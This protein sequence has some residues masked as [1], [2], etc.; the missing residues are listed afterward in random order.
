MAAVRLDRLSKTF[1]WRKDYVRAVDEVDLE[2]AD[3]EFMV[4]VGPSGCGKS[5]T[6]RL[7][8][9][10]EAPTAGRVFIDDKE[11]THLQPKDRDVA[12]VFQN[13]ALYPHMTAFDNLAF[14]LKM[15]RIPK[16]EIARRVAETARW[17]GL[18]RLLDRR[19]ATLSGGEQQRVALGRA[20]VRR[21]RVFLFDEPLANFDAALRLAAR[22]ELKR[23]HREFNITTIHVTHDQEEAMALADRLVVMRDGRVQQVGTPQE[24]YDR[25]VNRFVGGFL[26][27]PPMRFIE[28][29]LRMNGAAPVV[30]TSVG[31][32]AITAS[33][34][35]RCRVH[36]DQPV[37]L[38][39]R[40]EDAEFISGDHD[41]SNP[42]GGNSACE[43]MLS[44][45][46]EFVES[47][48]HCLHLG[49]RTE[50]EWKFVI[51]TSSG[52]AITVGTQGHLWL[53][54]Q[55]THLFAGHAG[56]ERLN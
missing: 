38:G 39:F 5:T 3:G 55:R 47:L 37:S 43:F 33:D 50:R 31:P 56:G 49:L 1:P 16:V 53:N 20:M 27:T 51:R 44:A 11:V 34:S 21:P 46:V 24:I 25:P 26:G 2:V 6:L 54:L 30:E 29:T 22:A 32:I 10:L 9:G 18:E 14:G 35:A 48:G 13:Y 8:A 7:I 45:S 15:R 42:S 41:Q 4:L 23:L 12:M 17:L 40:A 28:G 36:A 52:S 19:P